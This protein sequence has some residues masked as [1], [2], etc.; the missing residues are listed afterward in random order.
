M[1]SIG[2]PP[3][4]SSDIYLTTATP[5]ECEELSRGNSTEWKAALELDTYLL[6]E[7]HLANQDLTRD[8]GLTTWVLVWQPGSAADRHV[9]TGCETIKKRALVSRDGKVEDTVCHG[10][11]SVFCPP[12]YRGRGYGGRMISELGDKL[13]TWQMDQGNKNL[14]SALWSDI[15]KQFYAARGWH[16]Y[17]SLHITLPASEKPPGAG[18]QLLTS[19]DLAEVCTIDEKL[20][21]DRLQAC[22][23][24]GRT[25]VSFLPDHRTVAWHHARED[26]VSKAVLGKSP[27]V[28]GA[29]VGSVW[30]YWTRVWADPR[31]HD[32]NTL[33]IL[34]LVITDERLGADFSPAS[35]EGVETINA[36][37]EGRTQL[38]GLESSEVAE[39][40]QSIATILALAQTEAERWGMKEVMLWNPTSLTLAAARQVDN[41]VSVVERQSESIPS[42]RWYGDGSWEDVDWV[43]NMK[44]AWC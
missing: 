1:G 36:A 6:R 28:R 12:E 29:R 37:A 10:V 19:Q 2:L 4:D 18:V 34:R 27:T 40:K 3:K 14:L 21:R 35:S 17:A 11:G 39:T 7:K 5:A 31:G 15:G 23:N 43:E 20:M 44:Y 26:F 24:N 22:S 33:H 8:G 13:R 25:T 41:N 38:S 42:L 16:P 9:L 32:P 30:A